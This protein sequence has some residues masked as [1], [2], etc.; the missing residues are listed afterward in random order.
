MLKI[1]DSSRSLN[2]CLRS[3]P[4]DQ[5]LGVGGSQEAVAEEGKGDRG[6]E[7]A[8]SR[9]LE[10]QSSTAG[11]WGQLHWEPLRHGVGHASELSLHRVKEA[12][13][14]SLFLVFAVG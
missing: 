5:D 14:F 8:S 2:C 3:G 10:E 9:S 4:E 6:G 7:R 11:D 13:V 12:G 1:K